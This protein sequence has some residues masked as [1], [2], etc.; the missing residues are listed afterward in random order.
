MNA[1]NTVQ[2]VQTGFYGVSGFVPMARHELQWMPVIMYTPVYMG[3]SNPDYHGWNRPRFVSREDAATYEDHEAFDTDGNTAG[4]WRVYD[5]FV[6]F[7]REYPG[8]SFGDTGYILV[9]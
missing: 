7:E 1:I 8:S 5:S 2:T 3:I 6:E 4:F 9:P